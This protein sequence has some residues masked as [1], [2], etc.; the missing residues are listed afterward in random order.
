MENLKFVKLNILDP[1]IRHEKPKIPQIG[2]FSLEIT[3]CKHKT[4]KLN[5]ID[6]GFG[7]GR[8]E[9]FNLDTLQNL[10]IRHGKFRVI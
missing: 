6:L 5:I 4:F 3:H 8:L 9:T 1:Q 10:E 2:H 7:H